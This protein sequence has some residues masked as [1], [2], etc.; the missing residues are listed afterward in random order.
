MKPKPG[1]WKLV[2]MEPDGDQTHQS[3][4]QEPQSSES[5]SCVWYKP[6]HW[7]QKCAKPAAMTSPI[8]TSQRQASAGG[9][10]GFPHTVA[11]DDLE[12]DLREPE[13]GHAERHRDVDHSYL[14]QRQ[15]VV[16]GR[17]FTRERSRGEP[18]GLITSASGL[19]TPIQAPCPCE[20]LLSFRNRQSA[21][22]TPV[23]AR[24]GLKYGHRPRRS[25]AVS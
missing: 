25:F 16:E 3:G 20:I 10:R 11:V 22:A 6:A 9:F 23:A 5:R 12:V 19:M 4:N 14:E 2:D 1:M 21:P 15:P 17:V 13:A 8:S 7:A 24:E 18:G